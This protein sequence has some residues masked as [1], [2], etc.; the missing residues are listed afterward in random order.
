MRTWRAKWTNLVEV[1]AT[2]PTADAVGL[3]TVFNIAGKKYRLIVKIDYR[4]RLILMKNI[5][6]HAEYNKGVWKK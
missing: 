3:L 5:L 6:T 2:F 4:S 1:R